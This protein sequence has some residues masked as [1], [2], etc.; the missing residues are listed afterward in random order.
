MPAGM[1]AQRERAGSGGGKLW[2]GVDIRS[3]GEVKT[4]GTAMVPEDL[5]R[6]VSKYAVI[7]EKWWYWTDE[8][9]AR[10]IMLTKDS[11]YGVFER[12]RQL[13]EAS[14]PDITKRVQLQFIKWG[15]DR[16]PGRSSLSRLAPVISE[17]RGWC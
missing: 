15:L 1:A 2:F 16:A 10:Y 13:L 5:L 9:A 12:S 14:L 3:L 8:G 6:D 11:S 4:R 7:D 17:R